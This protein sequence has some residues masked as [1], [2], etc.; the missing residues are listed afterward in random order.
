MNQPDG[1]TFELFHRELRT[2][3]CQEWILNI[4]FVYVLRSLSVIVMKLNDEVEN[5]SPPP[6]EL[7]FFNLF[8]MHLCNTKKNKPEIQKLSFLGFFRPRD[9]VI[10]ESVHLS[11]KYID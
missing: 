9:F 11:F 4:T 10:T 2:N 6:L 3:R 7:I 8:L 5:S 1:R